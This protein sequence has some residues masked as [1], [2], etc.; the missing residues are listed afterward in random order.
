[1]DVPRILR[2]PE[3]L[4]ATGRGHASLYADILRGVMTES[5]RIGTQAVGWPEHEIA[6]INRARIAGNSEDEIRRLVDE[7][8]ASRKVAA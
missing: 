3:V 6:A 5:I 7:L 2:K 1:M 4:R 8:H